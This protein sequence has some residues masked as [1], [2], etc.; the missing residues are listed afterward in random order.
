MQAALHEH[1]HHQIERQVGKKETEDGVKT[2]AHP[3]TS[4]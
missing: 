3:K 1:C 4:L 2:G